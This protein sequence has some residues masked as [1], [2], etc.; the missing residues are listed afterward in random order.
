MSDTGKHPTA[1]SYDNW[2]IGFFV[3]CAVF[4]CVICVVVYEVI[5]A[6]S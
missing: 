3:F 2:V 5:R 4:T 6:I 1:E